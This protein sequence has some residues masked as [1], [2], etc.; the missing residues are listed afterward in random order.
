VAWFDMSD[1]QLTLYG[2]PV[3]NDVFE[4]MRE[5]LKNELLTQLRKR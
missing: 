3:K 5:K 2:K 1:V 4:R